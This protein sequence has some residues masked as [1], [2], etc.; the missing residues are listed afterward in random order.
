MNADLLTELGQATLA[1]SA[2]IVF[3]ALVR[4]PLRRGWGARVA[5]VLWVGAPLAVLA[6][7]L[8]APS[9]QTL[10]VI[11]PAVT[12]GLPQSLASA[13]TASAPAAATWLLPLWLL[14][15]VAFLIVIARR[16]TN[17][18]RLVQ[19]HAHLPYDEV[20]G[21]GP[22]VAGFLRPRIVLPTDFRERY[23]ADEQ[24][25]VLAHE[26]VH[27]RRGDVHAQTL[28][29]VLRCLFWFNPLVHYAA[30]RFRFD[31]ELACDA[32]VLQQFP[33]SR[34]TYGDAMLKTQL[35]EFGLPLGCHWP[36]NHPLKERIAMLKHPLPGTARRLSGAM[37]VA[38]VVATGSYAAWI[39]QP[40]YAAPKPSP[41]VAQPAPMPSVT[42]ITEGDV[43]TPPKYPDAAVAEG[44]RGKVML[45]LLV[46][47]DGNV[48][49]VQVES[50]EPAGVFDQAAIEAASQWHFSNASRDSDGKPVEGWVRVPIQFEP[51]SPAPASSGQSSSP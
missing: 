29:S 14:G 23:N 20:I 9:P 47:V 28:A 33:K 45:K 13:W 12:I 27:L 36:S 44:L 31:Q 48:K 6:V 49:Q 5:Y 42:R 43:L 39:A 46:G 50:S 11:A 35:A 17:F 7:L 22:A 2:A 40:A 15:M 38:V 30:T 16:Q 21:H 32:V 18:N 24:A 8:P 10:P 4:Q 25:L 1:I 51:D 34:R 3:I 19:R 41:T 37:L 26:Q